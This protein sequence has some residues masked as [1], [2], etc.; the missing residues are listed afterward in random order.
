M[1]RKPSAVPVVHQINTPF[2]DAE[3]MAQLH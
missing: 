1:E 3:S 2:F